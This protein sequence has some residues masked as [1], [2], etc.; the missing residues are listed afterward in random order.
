M[1]LRVTLLVV[2]A[3]AA[4]L[5]ALV[6]VAALSARPALF[7]G[8]GLVVSLAA[9]PAGAVLVRSHRGAAEKEVHNG[10]HPGPGA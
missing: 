4:G 2:A 9:T 7:L 6:G 1:L 8:A 10:H 5:V 3:A